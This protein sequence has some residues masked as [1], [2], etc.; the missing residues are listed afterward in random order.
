MADAHRL[1]DRFG[2]LLAPAGAAWAGLMRLREGFYAA[3]AFPRLLLPAP[4]CSVG[5]V[6]MGGTGKTPLTLWLCRRAVEEGLRPVVLTRGYGAHPPR[7]P[8]LVSPT[9]DPA[10]S[11]DEPLLLSRSCPG[12]RVVV[13]PVRRR[14]GAYA[15]ENLSPDLFLLD[16]G[17]QHLAVARDL[18]LC[19]LRPEDLGEAWG[20]TFPAGY[21]REGTAALE[22]AD[23]FVLKTPDGSLDAVGRAV[24]ERLAPYARPIFA[25]FLA[26]AGLRPLTGGPARTDLEREPY[27]VACGVAHPAQ[28]AATAEA[29]LGYPP[30]EVLAFADHHGFSGEDAARIASA[31]GRAGARHVVVTAKDAVKLGGPG[32]GSISSLV[33]VLEVEARFGER[34]FSDET[35]ET[36]AQRRLF[37]AA[38]AGRTHGQ[39]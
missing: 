1:L 8:W 25:F 26:P 33:S 17:F 36:F 15:A 3:G 9:D 28:V 19:L 32:A 6:A 20:R 11:G 23:A 34:L 21:W 27:V 35:F 12:A 39:A 18:N 10:E 2:P 4:V 38:R 24:R 30:E 13:D 31:A 22:R 14:G 5:N 29:F 37:A 7:L 16:D